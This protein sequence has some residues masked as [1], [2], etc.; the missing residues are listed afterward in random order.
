[1]AKGERLIFASYVG[2]SGGSIIN[3]EDYLQITMGKQNLAEKG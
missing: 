2:I 1:M 3:C